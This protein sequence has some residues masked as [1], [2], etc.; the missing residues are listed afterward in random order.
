MMIF[1]INKKIV[2]FPKKSSV[3]LLHLI[4]LGKYVIIILS[5]EKTLHPKAE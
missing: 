2:I 1:S 3:S 4:F 5:N